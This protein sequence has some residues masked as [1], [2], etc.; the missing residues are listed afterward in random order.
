MTGV[1]P[2]KTSAGLLMFRGAAEELAVFLVHPGGPFFRNKDEGAWTIPKGLIEPGEEPLDTAVREFTEETGLVPG[3]PY[4]P[5]APVKQKGGKTVMAGHDSSE[6]VLARVAAGIGTDPRVPGDRLR[7]VLHTG[8]SQTEAEP[9]A[10][11]IPR[12]AR[13]AARERAPRLNAEIRHEIPSN[14][15]QDAS[16]A[17][18]GHPDRRA[19][20]S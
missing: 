16:R 14:P 18:A 4:L 9:G 13:A 5:L 8:R 3:G 2:R 12:R 15:T 10:G 7:G 19:A 20:P 6:H 1:R 11:R 17:G